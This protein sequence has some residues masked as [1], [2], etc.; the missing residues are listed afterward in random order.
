MSNLLIIGGSDAGISAALR[1]REVDSSWDVTVLVADRF[2]N[3][4]ICGLPFWL[5][6]EIDDWH[7]LAHRKAQDI[8][9]Q[10]IELLLEHTAEA[11]DPTGK[12]VTVVDEA[13]R[14][15][16]TPYDSLV[17]GTGAVPARPPIDG[18]EHPGV[19]FLRT[20]GDGFALRDYLAEEQ[21]ASAVVV[22]GGYIG[23]EMAE[24][25]VRR[26]I[27][28]TLVE[29]F[30]SVLTTVDAP[31]GN[32]IEEVLTGRGATVV[33]GV[34]VESIERRGRK[35]L[36]NG[37]EGFRAKV[38][39]VLVATGVRPNADLALTAG[40]EAG[41]WGAIRVNRAMET[42][43]PDVYAAGDCVETYHRLLERNDYLPLGSTAHKQGRVAG[44][45]AVGGQAEFSGTL[46]TQVVKA[47]D[48]VAARTGLRDAEAREA[49]FDPL[50][51]QLET[52]D[53]KVY[54]PGAHELHIRVTG[55]RQ[56]GRLLGAQIVGHRTGA[57]SK[58]IDVFATALF[59]RMTVEALNDIDLSYTPPLSTPWDAVQVATQAWIG[60]NQ[61]SS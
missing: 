54:Y 19:F 14:S 42:N 2:P 28:V 24:A 3:C 50:T 30:P 55:D 16:Q 33:T 35:L 37:S 20:M 57:V 8:A 22:G 46:G 39:L 11:I 61:E 56:T 31:L 27:E 49:G 34:S 1:A 44:E 26:G 9:A 15:R 12:T 38:E 13:G 18:L 53:H 52:W 48:I 25:L 7:D 17:M 47:F 10:G 32:L 40:V 43:V 5:G 6:G 36:V 23:L 21:P 51:V 41:R 4:S 59:N 45:N 58:R 60:D 29:Y